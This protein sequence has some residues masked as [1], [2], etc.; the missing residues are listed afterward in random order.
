MANDSTKSDLITRVGSILAGFAGL[1]GAVAQFWK[2]DIFPPPFDKL[3]V[4]L[5]QTCPH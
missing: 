5:P 4:W 3:E 2:P 1:L